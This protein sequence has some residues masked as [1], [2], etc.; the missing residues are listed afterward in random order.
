[1]NDFNTNENRPK[2]ARKALAVFLAILLF[3]AGMGSGC[4]VYYFSLGSDLRRFLW[5]K[6]TIAD[7][8]YEE[9]S[10]AELYEAAIGGM[11]DLLDAYSEYYSADEY[12]IVYEGRQGHQSGIGVT[13][14]YRSEGVFLYRVSGNS[15]AEAAG[16]RAGMYITGIGKDA[17]SVTPVTGSDFVT[18]LDDFG[19]GELF[20]LRTDHGDFTLARGEYAENY[21]FYR[22]ALSAWSFTGEDALTPEE[23]GETL[24]LPAGTAYI[25]ITQFNG[26]M[27][28]QFVSALNIFRQEG[29]RNLILDLRNNGGGTL[30]TLCEIA[31]YLCKNAAERHPL[32]VRAKYRDGATDLYRASKNAYASYF[33]SDS[34]IFVLANYNTASASECLLGALL[35]Y[36]TISYDQ[37][38]L[39][40]I[41]GEARTYGKGIMQTTYE[42]FLQGG[43]M[44]LTTA[45]VHWP[46][47]GTCIHG[48]GILPEDGALP[49]PASASVTYDDE[50]LS[51][52]IARI[53]QRLS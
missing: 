2:R 39:S 41:D 13:V 23:R 45:T 50:E 9:F 15:P 42:N 36:G 26:S 3:L 22:S 19:E 33:S 1:M 37:I 29:N 44:K 43:A 12:E 11:T 8:Y 47:S 38:Y 30:S 31:S 16:L 4:L 24:P 7:R 17:A 25:R 52:V 51:E 34:R 53:T 32:V 14:Q 27:P 10:D 46:V 6:D 35:D 21:V 28:E 18:L 48:R 49:V 20:V 5:V 40:E